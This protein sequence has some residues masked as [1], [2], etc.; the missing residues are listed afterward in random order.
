MGGKLFQDHM[1]IARPMDFQQTSLDYYTTLIHVT[2][3]LLLLLPCTKQKKSK[4]EICGAL[5]L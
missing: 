3:L 2:F 4:I 5:E 1:P